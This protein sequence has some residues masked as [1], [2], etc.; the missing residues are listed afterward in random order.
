VKFKTNSAEILPESDGVLEAV[1]DILEQHSKITKLSIEGHTDSVGKAPYN[2]KLSDRRAASVLKW[3][4]SHGIDKSRMSSI[5]YGMEKPLEDNKTEDGRRANRR[6][7]FHIE[8]LQG[9]A[10]SSDEID[11]ESKSEQVTPARK[12]STDHSDQSDDSL[13]DLG[14]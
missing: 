7:E 1:R 2:K 8:E 6:V 10:A 9:K 13:G 11:E 12:D 14:L 5:G 4:V 3:L